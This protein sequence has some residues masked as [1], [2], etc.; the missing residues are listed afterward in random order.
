M[1]FLVGLL[2][3][4]LVIVFFVVIVAFGFLRSLFRLGR[5]GTHAQSNRPTSQHAN[6]TAHAR[7]KLFDKDDGEYADFEEIK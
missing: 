1:G 6:A 4:I 3:F 2:L 7:K 5:K